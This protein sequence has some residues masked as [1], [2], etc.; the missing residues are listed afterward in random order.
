MNFGFTRAV[1]RR[2]EP[3][4]RWRF[5]ERAARDPKRPP[6]PGY[7]GARP[8]VVQVD[9]EQPLQPG[10]LHGGLGSGLA[11]HDHGDR[12]R[13][14]AFAAQRLDG[15]ERGLTGGRGVLEDDDALA[16]DIRPF[17]LTTAAVILRLLAHDERVERAVGARGL[18]HDRVRDR[19]GAECQAADGDDAVDIAD[20]VEHDPA[21]RGGGAVV[22]RELAHVDVVGGLLAAREREVAVEHGLGLDQVDEGQPVGF[23]GGCRGSGH[24]H[25]SMRPTP[26]RRLPDRHRH[27]PSARPSK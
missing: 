6:T 2:V 22:E 5:R 17:H 27:P 3:E 23:D 26:R 15:L 11:V 1:E 14:G 24:A 4:V 18:V 9:R 12:D 21:D 8:E 13:L 20:Q 7:C 25:E 10:G 16:R 19:V